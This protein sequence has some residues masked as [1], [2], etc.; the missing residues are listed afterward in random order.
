MASPDGTAPTRA[1]PP[2]AKSGSLGRVRAA[3]VFRKI[4][5]PCRKVHRIVADDAQ[6]ERKTSWRK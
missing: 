2:L 3:I 6:C 5:P 1:A 4:L